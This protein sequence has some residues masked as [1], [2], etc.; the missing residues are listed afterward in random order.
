MRRMQSLFLRL[1]SC[2]VL[3]LLLFSLTACSDDDGPVFTP[4]LPNS[5]GSPV[6]QISHQGGVVTS[7]DWNLNYSSQR[8]TKGQGQIRDPRPDIDK[9]YQYTS[10]I[11]YGSRGITIKNSDNAAVKVSLNSY[12]YIERMTIGRNIYEFQYKDRYL[13][14]WSKT[15]FE[16][17]FGQAVEYKSSGNI[18][19]ENGD[20]KSIVVTEPDMIPVTTTFTPDTR[21]NTNGL[22]PVT[23]SKGMGCLGFEHLF[24]AG[25]LGKPTTHLVKS[26]STYHPSDPEQCYTINFEY[27]IRGNNVILCNYNT[28]NGE[29]A[30]VIFSY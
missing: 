3:S 20:L 17:N 30:S 13:S 25:L 29:P 28:P 15:I 2:A 26:L 23:A 14:G 12:G 27:S 11:S 16:D 18:T 21:E 4:E 19:Y 22:L 5:T 6:R 1:G 7:Y 10:K 9:S 8:L 24:Y